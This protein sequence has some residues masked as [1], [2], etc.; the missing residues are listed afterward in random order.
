[1]VLRMREGCDWSNQQHS[2]HA[3]I[4]PLNPAE[5]LRSMIGRKQLHGWKVATLT[6]T[7]DSLPMA[8]SNTT[9]NIVTSQTLARALSHLP[10]LACVT[11]AYINCTS[12]TPNHFSFATPLLRSSHSYKSTVLQPS[13]INSFQHVHGAQQ[14]HHLE[15]GHRRL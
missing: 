13:C 7:M 6:F 14:H 2:E 9:H 8:S 11:P 3:A 12:S 5:R 10:S 4:S 1:M 15:V